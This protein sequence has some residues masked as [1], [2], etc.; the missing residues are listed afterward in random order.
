[1]AAAGFRY[2]ADF[3]YS[4]R[5]LLN[6]V[7]TNTI[8]A[9]DFSKSVEFY[10]EGHLNQVSAI[11]TVPGSK[12]VFTGCNGGFIK[13]W[14]CSIANDGITTI[15][16]CIRDFA[17]VKGR[18]TS[19]LYI[20]GTSSAGVHTAA[21][22]V[23][24]SKI[25]CA[26]SKGK[27]HI[28]DVALGEEITTC[29]DPVDADFYV[30]DICLGL[31]GEVIGACG[32]GRL[33]YWDLNSGR[34]LSTEVIDLK[35]CPITSLLTIP[36]KG[37]LL[38]G[39]DGGGSDLSGNIS[40][41]SL[42]DRKVLAKIIVARGLRIFAIQ[43]LPNVNGIAVGV[44]DGSLKIFSLYLGKAGPELIEKISLNVRH[45]VLSTLELSSDASRLFF[46][47]HKYKE[48]F[49]GEVRSLPLFNIDFVIDPDTHFISA[50]KADV[51]ALKVLPASQDALLCG[52]EGMIYV[53]SAD[54]DEPPITLK[55]L[56]IEAFFPK[57]YD[58]SGYFA[59]SKEYMMCLM[60]E[61]KRNISVDEL[62]L[63]KIRFDQE[64]F[65]KLIELLKTNN[66]IRVVNMSD[67][68]ITN[69][70]AKILFQVV[71]EIKQIT[72]ILVSGNGL[73]WDISNEFSDY[74]H[75]ISVKLRENWGLF[76]EKE[77]AIMSLLR[78]ECYRYYFLQIQRLA[79]QGRDYTKLLDE[80][81]AVSKN[82]RGLFERLRTWF[83]D[84]QK[85]IFDTIDLAVKGA[86]V[87]GLFACAV[88]GGFERE[89]VVAP[90]PPGGWAHGEAGEF[91]GNNP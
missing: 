16:H 73:S 7:R 6:R 26:T 49:V 28:F 9:V 64:M 46:A 70:M 22:S 25:A 31:N 84:H 61:L 86:L 17:N 36:S 57:C 45:S 83:K 20:G 3:S 5:L 27:I 79:L 15:P 44:S 42:Y 56:S 47:Y 59:V 65:D 67:T 43:F 72:V 32:D 19:L 1:M 74:S 24:P 53:A 75:K 76:C 13:M 21:S 82:D 62:N 38:C 4:E 90:P 77:Q 37:L 78:K 39:H 81:I 50:I 30:L 52:T 10:L 12:I 8:D 87:V 48:S 29:D 66:R 34:L 69:E 11:A 85:V 41:C 54:P 51:Y 33:R 88:K 35:Q 18:I 63:Y 58:G 71:K 2:A 40:I 23:V 55:N 14:D 80:F 60:D 89:V 91:N 68:G